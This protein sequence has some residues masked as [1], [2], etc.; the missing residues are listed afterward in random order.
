MVRDTNPSFRTVLD[1]YAAANVVIAD[2]L[3][4][5]LKW[6]H[7][8]GKEPAATFFSSSELSL[9]GPKTRQRKQDLDQYIQITYHFSQP[10][11]IWSYGLGKHLFHSQLAFFMSVLV[12]LC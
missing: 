1:Y 8:S 11:P 10:P 9:E 3:D 5:R 4:V 12:F 7:N 6:L 2:S